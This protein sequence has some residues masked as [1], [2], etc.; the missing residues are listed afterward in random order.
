MK[1]FY[2]ISKELRSGL[3][4]LMAVEHESYARKTSMQKAPTVEGHCSL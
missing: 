4:H 1:T 3:E 2:C